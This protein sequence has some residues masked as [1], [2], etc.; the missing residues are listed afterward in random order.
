METRG[1]GGSRRVKSG[2]RVGG[3]SG[4]GEWEGG[5]V[6]EQGRGEWEGEERKGG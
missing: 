5:E 6:G 4:G 2:G 3:E 1:E